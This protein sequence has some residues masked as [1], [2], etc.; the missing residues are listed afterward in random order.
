MSLMRTRAQACTS[1]SVLIL[2]RSSRCIVN[3]VSE[4]LD[5]ARRS[6]RVCEPPLTMIFSGLSIHL[7]R[8]ILHI[9]DNM[10]I[11]SLNMKSHHMALYP[12]YWICIGIVIS[13][14]TSFAIFRMSCTC[15]TDAIDVGEFVGLLLNVE[16]KSP[17]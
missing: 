17:S 7:H 4:S 11:C 5:A 3:I 6:E 1:D 13:I 14:P 8:I 10:V 2:L 9:L 16:Q 15:S 12:V